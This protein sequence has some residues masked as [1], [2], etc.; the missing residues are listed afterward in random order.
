M[1]QSGPFISMCGL[2][3]TVPSWI[4]R[5]VNLARALERK[6][7]KVEIAYL[8]SL[9]QKWSKYDEQETSD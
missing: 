5:D 9:N 2:N 6:R 1:S 7:W 8:E 4:L 3:A